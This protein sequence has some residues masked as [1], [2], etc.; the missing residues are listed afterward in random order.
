MNFYEKAYELFIYLRDPKQLK[1]ILAGLCLLLAFILLVEYA[2]NR[3]GPTE[4]QAVLTCPGCRLT[5]AFEITKL[6]DAHCPKCGGGMSYLYK[7]D[8][9]HYEFA[10]KPKDRSYEEQR[11]PNCK[12][13]NTHEAN[14]PPPPPKEEEEK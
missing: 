2:K 6:S 10:Y 7:C 3:R 4:Y 9:C 1:L 14:P 5:Q 8:D 13:G 11:C 12:S